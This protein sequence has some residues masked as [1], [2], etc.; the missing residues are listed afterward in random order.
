M[1]RT[2][3]RMHSI[4]Q[5]KEKNLWRTCGTDQIGNEDEHTSDECPVSVL[6]SP[7]SR[8]IFRVVSRL[9][10]YDCVEYYLAYRLNVLACTWLF[11][12]IRRVARV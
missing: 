5:H 1:N 8:L 3:S 6:S 9:I 7:A 11:D 12:Q 4:Y 10:S 2:L